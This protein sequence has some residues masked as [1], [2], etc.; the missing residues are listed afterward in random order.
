MT[1]WG[2]VWVLTMAGALWLLRDDVP[3]WTRARRVTRAKGYLKG[4]GL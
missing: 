4:R 2:V 1:L 3:A